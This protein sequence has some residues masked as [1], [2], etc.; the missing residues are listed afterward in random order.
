MMNPTNS[1]PQAE[2]ER[3]ADKYGEMNGGGAG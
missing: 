3:M 2:L 1:T